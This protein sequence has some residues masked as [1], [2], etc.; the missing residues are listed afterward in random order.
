MCSSP[1][2]RRTPTHGRLC[3]YTSGSSSSPLFVLP[4]NPFPWLTFPRFTLP[5]ITSSLVLYSSGP[6]PS[7]ERPF[8]A[9]RPLEPN[10]SAKA[11]RSPPSP[12]PLPHPYVPPF[13]ATHFSKLHVIIF[14]SP[15]GAGSAI[16]LLFAGTITFTN[17][18]IS[19][20]K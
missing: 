12:L 2:T 10:T 14:Y 15:E 8:L 3:S 9:L 6:P 16:V 19:P 5:L 4:F 11:Y 18:H 17:L 7:R 20:Q 13:S 1:P